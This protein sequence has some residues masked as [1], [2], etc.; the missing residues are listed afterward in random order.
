MEDSVQ[1]S[2]DDANQGGSQCSNLPADPPASDGDKLC[3]GMNRISL[4]TGLPPK[5]S[6]ERRL[7]ASMRNSI[8]FVRPLNDG[9]KK[10]FRR[11]SLL[12]ATMR[13]FYESV[14]ARDEAAD[15]MM[16]VSEL[17][18]YLTR[19]A[20]T[21]LT[22]D[23]ST[24]EQQEE[25]MEYLLWEGIDLSVNKIDG[26]GCYGVE[27]VE[28]LFWEAYVMTQDSGSSLFSAGDNTEDYDPDS[29]VPASKRVSDISTES[30][31]QFENFKMLRATQNDTEE[32]AVVWQMD[33]KSPMRPETL[34]VA[35]EKDGVV[36]PCDAKFFKRRQSRIADD[37]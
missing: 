33:R 12:A 4:R 17:M 2:A 27:V 11:D 18:A 37:D 21:I 28:G 22:S 36:T 32:K 19:D 10:V 34:V 8:Q 31:V 23:T 29:K 5:Q 26:K 25:V 30:D 24:A 3:S 14:E 35:T 20:K 13:I 6:S 16:D 1:L 7:R 9:V 15:M